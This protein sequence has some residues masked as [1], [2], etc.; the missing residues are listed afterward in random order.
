MGT[1]S[2]WIGSNS[3]PSTP[4]LQGTTSSV[5][6]TIM[7]LNNGKGLIKYEMTWIFD[8][9]TFQGTIVEF[10]LVQQAINRQQPTGRLT[11]VE[12]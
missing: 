11:F 2:L 4:N 10:W 5:I 6:D 9:G 3:S 7:N 12:Y 1:I 8:G